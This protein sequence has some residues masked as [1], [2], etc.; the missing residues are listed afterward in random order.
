MQ[1]LMP[2]SFPSA[3]EH[4][5]TEITTTSTSSINRMSTAEIR[6]QDRILHKKMRQIKVYHIIE[7]HLFIKSPAEAKFS[8]VSFTSSAEASYGILKLSKSHFASP[9]WEMSLAPVKKS[10]ISYLISTSASISFFLETVMP[11]EKPL[12]SAGSRR[13]QLWTNFVRL[14]FSRFLQTL[15]QWENHCRSEATGILMLCVLGKFCW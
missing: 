3:L 13:K 14:R 12:T 9:L 8:A 6:Y 7:N 15:N 4:S 10:I 11:M 2:F 1:P 5:W